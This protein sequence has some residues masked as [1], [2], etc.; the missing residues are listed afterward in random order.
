MRV[1]L[2]PGWPIMTINSATL[3]YAQ[4]DAAT[5]CYIIVTRTLGLFVAFVN[6]A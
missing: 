2:M 5:H 1:Q 6:Y 3:S 4:Y